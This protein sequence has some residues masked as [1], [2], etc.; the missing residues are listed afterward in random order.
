MEYNGA[1]P[2]GN[3]FEFFLQWHLTEQCNLACTHCYQD[4]KR[5]V[6]M[7]LPEIKGTIKHISDTISQWSERYEIPFSVSFNV[8]GGEPLLRED[9][10]NILREIRNHNFHVS[11]LTNGT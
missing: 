2:D 10:P 8:T 11:L 1:V 9:L 5:P 6:E 7:A 4:G 3:N